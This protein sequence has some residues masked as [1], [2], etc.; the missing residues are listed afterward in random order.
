[1]ISIFKSIFNTFINFSVIFVKAIAFGS[2]QKKYAFKMLNL[3]FKDGISSQDHQNIHFG[4]LTP[5]VLEKKKYFYIFL[6]KIP[7]ITIIYQ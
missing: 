5:I 1:M 6:K 2:S 7:Q 3:L 4:S